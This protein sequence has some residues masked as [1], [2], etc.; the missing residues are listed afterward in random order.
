MT[1]RLAAGWSGPDRSSSRFSVGAGRQV[2]DGV[3]SIMSQRDF[4]LYPVAVVQIIVDV[5]TTGEG[6]P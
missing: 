3:R 1:A 5:T 4:R 6:L 2:D